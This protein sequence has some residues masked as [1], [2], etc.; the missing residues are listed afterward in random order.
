M[1]PI[2]S[3]SW[4]QGLEAAVDRGWIHNRE[5]AADWVE[6]SLL[7]SLASTEGPLLLRMHEALQRSDHAAFARWNELLLAL[8]ETSE[9]YQED[10]EQGDLL[11]RLSRL[12]SPGCPDR[13]KPYT[14]AA[15]F[16]EALYEAAIPIKEGTLGFFYMWVETQVTQII[17]LLPLGLR[18]GQAL[19][20]Q[21]LLK[22]P[23]AVQTSRTCPDDELGFTLPGRA[24]A[25]CFHESQYCR[26]YRS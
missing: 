20:N 10:I 23:K 1:L 17:K 18:D 12:H 3:F 19:L 9:L 8:R 6:A 16:A 21:V 22:V 26:I 4:S 25:S 7:H 15:A 13:L 24:L 5:S 11:H 14:L 2:G